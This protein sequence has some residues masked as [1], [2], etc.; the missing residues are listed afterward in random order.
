MPRPCSICDHPQ[1]QA[2]D[3]A[4]VS[5]T[6]FRGIARRFAASE[7]AIQRHAAHHLRDLLAQVQREQTS[8]MQAHASALGQQVQAH[9]DQEQ[10][11]ALDVMTELHRCFERVTLLFDAC[12]R[13]LRDADD[14]TRY[15]IGPRADDVQVT[16]QDVGTDGKPVRRKAALSTLLSRLEAGG[17]VVERWES[18]YADPRDLLIKTAAQLQGQT[19]LLARLLGDLDERPQFNVLVSPE[20]AA[21][22]GALLAALRPY[23]DAR[24]AVAGALLRLETDV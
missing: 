19:Q 10:A 2:I 12:D 9:E 5:G 3:T 15:D 8:A 4:I 14:P 7:D 17:V 24:A 13:W 11:H 6:A 21:L 22:R 18:K 1:R 16:Y 23:P 20:W